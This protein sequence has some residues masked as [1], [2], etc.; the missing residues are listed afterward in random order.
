[1][2]AQNKSKPEQGPLRPQCAKLISGPVPPL[3]PWQD[4]HLS[5]SAQLQIILN[6]NIHLVN[7][8]VSPLMAQTSIVVL[9][10]VVLILAVVLFSTATQALKCEIDFLDVTYEGECCT[11]HY[12]EKI[13]RDGQYYCSEPKGCIDEVIDHIAQSPHTVNVP[14]PNKR[15]NEAT[16]EGCEIKCGFWFRRSQSPTVSCLGTDW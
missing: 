9:R 14:K 15:I 8:S 3:S 1:M 5:C 12:E 16:N 2:V 7:F 10:P 13:Y 6:L 4:R 11:D